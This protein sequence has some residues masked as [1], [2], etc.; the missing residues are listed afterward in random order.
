MVPILEPE[1]R[2]NH[3]DMIDPG[4]GL[5]PIAMDCL[6]FQENG[7]PSSEELCQRLAGLKET[8]EYR[9]SVEQVERMQN[10]IAQ[11]EGHIREMQVREAATVQQ[12]QE[13]REENQQLLQRYQSEIQSKDGQ[14]LTLNQWRNDHAQSVDKL[15]DG[16]QQECQKYQN[17]LKSN[18][19]EIQKLRHNL[20]EEQEV[21]AQLQQTNNSLQRQV[22][23]LQ[24]RGSQDQ[25]V[26]E[27]QPYP[28]P[29][30][31]QYQKRH[32]P[33]RQMKVGEWRES[34]NAR[35][36]LARGAAVVDGSVVYF[37]NFDGRTCSFDSSTEIWRNLPQYYCWYSGLAIIRGLLTAI[38]GNKNTAIKE[39]VSMVNKK[40]VEHFPPM[41][42]ERSHTA[43]VSTKQ[44]LIV[45]GGLSQLSPLN[46][47]E[48]M[49]IEMLVWSTAASLPHPYSNASATICG[50]HFYVLG[51]FQEGNAMTKSVL[52]CSLPRLLHKGLQSCSGT[53]P[54]SVWHRITDVPVYHSTCAAI[55]G[56]LVAVGG[57]DGEH[58]SASSVHKYNPTTDSWD[59]ID[60]MLPTARYLSLVAILPTVEIMITGGQTTPISITD[61]VEIGYIVIT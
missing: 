14:I 2:K 55:D 27:K 28:L 49:N 56:E 6:H 18:D 10:D 5:L 52:T 8:R 22:E 20:E 37:M 43:V 30:K 9:E 48:V 38:S 40:W 42:T 44:H 57:C 15:R 41:A 36:D 29:Q 46:T 21:T 25:P 53:S 47:V 60:N 13:L 50:D 33:I 35:H 1:R 11:L 58:E 32:P 26:K 19:M 54:S 12:L 7:R 3:I 59:I 34:E 16:F 61:Q 23:Q 24:L 17:E 4:H 39:L 31:I 51:G 45:A